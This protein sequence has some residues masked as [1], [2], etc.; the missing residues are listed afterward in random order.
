MATKR[1]GGADAVHDPSALY[2]GDLPDNWTAD[3]VQDLHVNLGLADGTLVDVKF[4]PKKL[5]GETGC[6]IL[7]Y[8]DNASAARALAVLNGIPVETSSGQQKTVRARYADSQTKVARTARPAAAQPK[9]H[10][11]GY[12]SAYY[13][14]GGPPLGQMLQQGP[15][16]AGA[17]WAS[18]AAPHHGSSGA[19]QNTHLPS[20][21]VSEIPAEFTDQSINAFH[22]S[23]GLN[24]LVGVKFLPR[25]ISG[26]TGSVMLRYSSDAAALQAV[27]RLN[28]HP[29][30]L[31]TGAVK[32]LIAKLAS[33]PKGDEDNEWSIVP[34]GP[35]PPAALEPPEAPSPGCD[36]SSLYL[37][38]VPLGFSKEA[39]QRLHHESNLDTPM[40]MKYLPQKLDGETFCVIL[41]YSTPESA[42]QAIQALHCL[43]V[44]TPSGK[45]RFIT[46]RFAS[47]K[48]S[49]AEDALE[50][51]QAPTPR[52]P[53]GHEAPIIGAP[54]PGSPG[55]WGSND[56]SSGSAASGGTP[57]DESL[58]PSAYVSDLPGEI[59]EEG[60]RQLLTE[61]GL[62]QSMMVCVKFL[63]RKI[64]VNSICAI[65]RCHEMG[66]VNEI[67]GALSGHTVSL[68]NGQTRHLIARVA[69]PPKSSARATFA[70][71]GGYTAGSARSTGMR[72]DM[73]PPSAL[74]PTDLYVSEVPVDWNEE[75][76]TSFHGEVGLDPASVASVK[77]LERRHISYPTGA[78]IIRYVDHAAAS[79]AMA[80]LQG[81]PVLIPGGER[82]LVARFADPPRKG[83]Q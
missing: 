66:S 33:P 44:M 69:D 56:W 8:T 28:G 58:L 70:A 16:W 49:E 6:A 38:D 21:Y 41:R 47:L 51:G 40:S 18:A 29:V 72:Q 81:R 59:T 5:R 60:I 24:S 46:A 20:V 71:S 26:L 4:L 63:P 50:N 83:G 45:Q 2:V 27:Q 14:K 25:K 17:G 1:K 82:H 77:I 53:G 23:I 73:M 34:D 12:P 48:R 52:S 9:P 67:V 62:D 32:Y 42:K 31:S 54:D 43:S 30:N 68:A 61:V 22:S 79:S 37:A 80:A 7:R 57:E 10:M 65:L 74:Q 11:A 75:Y 39:M 36:P 15:S 35:S 78:A 3:D 19:G 76:V 64:Q 55:D 13:T